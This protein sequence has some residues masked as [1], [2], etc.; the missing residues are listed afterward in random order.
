MASDCE[1]KYAG[2]SLPPLLSLLSDFPGVCRV[3]I[4]GDGNLSYALALARHG[5][6]P[7]TNIVATSFESLEELRRKYGEELIDE[8]RH[9]LQ[10]L[11]A[12]VLHNV[13]AKNLEE[14]LTMEPGSPFAQGFHRVVFNVCHLLPLTKVSTLPQT[15]I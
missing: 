3:L 6:V 8:T 12:T 5:S 9:G 4:V 10:K 1:K 13:D 14:P 15:Y 2:H 7:A 11:G